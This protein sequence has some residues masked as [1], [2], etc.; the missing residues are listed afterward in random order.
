MGVG[1]EDASMFHCM[2]TGRIPPIANHKETDPELGNLNLSKGGD[3][4]NIQYGLRFA[5]GFGSQMALS[6]V[7]KWPVVGERIDGQRFLAWN[8]SL[9]NTEDVV[10]RILDNKLVAYINGDDRLH[11]GVQGEPWPI[12]A[13][14]EGKPSEVIPPPLPDPVQATPL[15]VEPTVQPVSVVP[16]PA[17]KD[18]DLVST[19]IEVVVN[20]TGY[21]ADFV[22]L[23]QDLE[24]ELGIDT[25]KQAEIMADI[26]ERFALPLDEEFVLSDYPTLTHMIGYIQKMTTGGTPLPIVTPLVASAVSEASAAPTPVDIPVEVPQI[27]SNEQLV[28]LVVEVVVQHTGYPADFVELD[29][30]LEGELGI[31]TVKQAEIMADIREQFTLPLD[32]DFV[33]SDYPT[34]NHMI[35][36]I[37][38]MQ[39]GSPMVKSTPT[40]A[41]AA[42][43]PIPAQPMTVPSPLP[44]VEV[45][46]DS[47]LTS[48]V[49]EVVV[50]HTGYPSDFIELDQDLEG[51]LGIDTVK[52]AEIMA[53]IRERFTLPLDEEFVLS[54]YPTLNHMIG[55][56]QRMKGGAPA[57][58]APVASAPVTPVQPATVTPQP[59]TPTVVALAPST[60]DSNIQ[61]QLIEVVV[62]HTGYPNDFIELDQDLEGELGID[63]VKQAEIMADVRDLFELPLDEDFVLSDH[64]TLNHFTAYI[65]RMKGSS[66]VEAPSASAVTEAV[67]VAMAP[68]IEPVVAGIERQENCRRW[69]VEVEGCPGTSS[70]LALEGT[71]VVTDDG[72]GIAEAFCQRVEARGM[73][74]VRIGFESEIRD[75]SSHQEAG[76]TV[77]RADP[78]NPE[79][80]ALVCKELEQLD[81]AGLVHMAPMKL[82]G[83]SWGDDTQPSS[84]IALSA[85]G[86]FS[87]LQGLDAH[88]ASRKDGLVA[89]VTAMDGRHGNIG[90][91]FN[92]VQCA[93]S[94][95]TKSY[96]F[97]QTHLRMRALD[98][99]P[100]LILDADQAAE[101]IDSDLFEIGGEIEIGLDRDGRRW[102]LVAF[103][104]DLEKEMTPLQSDD[105]W[106]VSGG[107]SGVTAASI[108]G[109]ACNSLNAGAH[110][111]LLGRS[112]LLEETETWV[113]WSTSRLD[114]QKN[115]LREELMA[116]SESG[117]VTMVEWNTAWQKYSRSRDVY[118]TIKTIQETGND[119]SYHS[120]DVMDTDGLKQLGAS[121]GRPITGIIHGAGLEDSKLVASKDYNVFDKVI[122][123]KIDGWH[124]LLSAV[125]ASSGELRFASCFTSV[126]GRFGNNGQTD[127]SAANSVLDAEMA[128]LTASGSCRAVAI[129]W[130][131]WRD[132]GMATRGSFQAVFDAAGIDTISV[133]KGVEIF[134]DEALRGGKR[135]VLGCGNLGTMDAFDAFREAPLRLPAEM[136][137]IIA[138]PFRFPFIDKVLS[139]DERQ[140]LTTQ[141]TLSV[142]EHPFLSD[143]A[144]DGVPYHPGV[145][146]LEMFAENALLLRPSACLAGFENVSFG[147]PVKLLKGEM[148]VRVHAELIRGDGE[149]SWI[150]CRLLSDLS[151]S[152]G[153]VFGEREHHKAIVRVV[154][155]REDL[156]PFLQSEVEALPQLGT[157]A[158]GELVELP[159]FI[160][161]RYFH[162][163]RFQSHGGVLRGI[164]DAETPGAD[165][166]AL[167]RHQ[168][169]KLDQ[170]ALEA[171]GEVVL[172]ES[173]PML[174]EAGFQNAGLVAMESEGFSS[175]PVGIE[176]SSM[177]RVPERNEVLRMRSLRTAV[178][179]AGITVHD[180]VV[181]GDDDAPVIALKGLRLKS[182]APVPEGESFTLER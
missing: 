28:N 162:G 93:A 143:H 43:S 39:G 111:A 114:E 132:V 112:T 2:K 77:Y 12:T 164:G 62:R 53:D 125:E 109:V 177:L 179:D 66:A 73:R 108:I 9:A 178:E 102:T 149:M 96:Y 25:V 76:R 163:P 35:G 49:V 87:L 180:V 144:I 83:A 71:I 151:N 45:I 69:Q 58:M 106:I 20:H 91:R 94:G 105:T 15:V 131:G 136:T 129:A 32:E 84:Q 86:Y 57:P 159:S 120:V 79:H 54:D 137:S 171:Q 148:A 5:A 33:L 8:R 41:V 169:P 27:E 56:I 88:L 51:E 123:V 42:P 182:M 55:Y 119:A 140:S 37:Q 161:R 174:I 44:A 104:E 175:L 13:A 67:P 150:A 130:T 142:A 101:H 146:A 156:G 126:S 11:G 48:I 168:L 24:G 92:S 113:E 23:D 74:A 81:V 155:S 17:S 36:Y 107:G 75:M 147:L 141:T 110:F 145:M 165:G 99:H 153:E 19:V 122:R 173:L 103:A 172:L 170:F 127:Y 128:R 117:K 139:V 95:V 30:D 1:I 135:R 154:E 14:W 134:V 6:L 40:S 97:E 10:M 78:A 176:W 124:S 16:S 50:Q 166:I 115:A 47:D 3:Y 85:H 167:M 100:E 29:Q 133:E 70:L 52:Q 60:A 121:L 89:S 90:E 98:L 61:E 158:L 181:V 46:E 116:A 72:W 82:A 152:K 7:R 21:P 59:S 118:I 64:P 160:Y 65:H 68:V 26:R 22:E 4:S 34:L 31:D 18:I 80:L 38:R 157:P 63:T 138:D